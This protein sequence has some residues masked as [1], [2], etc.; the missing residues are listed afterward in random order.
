MDAKQL[1]QQHPPPPYQ[2]DHKLELLSIVNNVL[3]DRLC[4]TI[5]MYFWTILMSALAIALCITYIVTL[6]TTGYIIIGFGVNF[7]FIL[8]TVIWFSTSLSNYEQSKTVDKHAKG[9]Y[10]LRFHVMSLGN[11]IYLP[12]G[13]SFAFLLAA[14]AL[15]S[16]QLNY[17]LP[18]GPA[19]FNGAAIMVF[20][21]CASFQ[22]AKL[23][24]N[25][26]DSKFWGSF[27]ESVKNDP[28]YAQ[29]APIVNKI[30]TSRLR[31]TNKWLSWVTTMNILSVALCIVYVS[32]LDM[33]YEY[34]LSFGQNFFALFGFGIWFSLAITDNEQGGYIDMHAK[35]GYRNYFAATTSGSRTVMRVLVSASFFVVFVVLFIYQSAVFPMTG[36]DRLNAY[37]TMVFLIC[38]TIQSAQSA[39]NYFDAKEWTSYISKLNQMQVPGQGA[40]LV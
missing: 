13:G 25:F 24:H 40:A 28:Q 31:S 37:A 26:T 1:D 35:N 38:T 16:Y 29:L 20:L 6:D 18:Y 32:T 7:L 12:L 14:I 33:G 27:I 21:L 15:F 39:Y 9:Q 30:L 19:R 3:V 36:P 4:S 5:K 17:S 11:K 8:C 22:A 23:L 34:N 10:R 2:G